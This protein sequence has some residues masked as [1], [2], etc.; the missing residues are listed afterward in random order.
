MS[1][2]V[3]ARGFRAVAASGTT[4][5]TAQ[6]AINKV[7]TLASMWLVAL[8]LTP[9]EFGMATL[10]LSVGMF[11][12]VLPPMTMGDVLVTHA[13]RFERLARI[14]SRIANTIGL[15]TLIGIALL[16][17][18][19]GRAYR[20]YPT[21]IL[22]GLIW[23]VSLR[24]MA[25][26]L[27]SVPLAR[28]RIGYRYKAIALI[29]GFTQIGATLLTV[30]LAW[31]GTGALAMVLP[32]VAVAFVRAVLYI[33][34]PRER[35][36]VS[37]RVYEGPE[38]T[39]EERRTLVGEFMIAS[40]AQYVHN[41]LVMLP[42]LVL[43]FFSTENETGLYAFA[44]T[45]SAQ[46]NT[47]VAAQ[48]GTVLQPIFVGLGTGSLRQVE[49][50]LRVV[51]VI[52]AAAVPVCL[53]QAALAEP[54][55]DLVFQDKWHGAIGVFAVL[56]IL[57]SSYFATAPTMAMLRAQGRFGAYFGW[58]VT[59][60]TVAVIAFTF[61]ARDHGA[62]GVAAC[63][64]VIWMAALPVA[65][66]LCTRPP[67]GTVSGA[68]RV[69]LMPWITGVPIALGAWFAWTLL[70][71]LGTPGMVIALLVV[72]PV[73]LWLSMI[74]TRAFQ[75][76]E[77]DELAR[78][79]GGVVR[80]VLR[81]SAA[82]ATRKPQ[83][84]VMYHFYPHYRRAIVETLARSEVADFTF[85]GD[86]HEYLRS[87]EPAK[88]SS[89]V[90]FVLAPTHHM[91]GPFMWQWGAIAIAWDR[92]FDTV[93]FHPVPHWPCTWIGAVLARIFG[94][95][96]LYWGH[97]ILETPRGV[98]GMLR[99]AFNALPHIQM[100]YSRRP[101]A[102][103]IADGWPPETLHVI[104][105]SED[106][107][108]QIAAR[109]RVTLERRRAVRRE[110]FGDDAT[111]VL[112][113]TARLIAIR[114]FDLLVEA[115]AILNRDGHPVNL[116]LV[117]DGPERTRLEAL[118]RERGVRAHFEGACYDEH[119]L[120]ELTMACNASVLPGR[121]G[122]TA[123]HSMVYGV[124]VVTHSDADDQHPEFEAIIPGRT[125]ALFTKDDAQSLADAL[126]PLIST[127]FPSAE[128]SAACHGIVE[129]FWNPTYQRRAIERA[130][131]G[132]PADDLFDL[133]EPRPA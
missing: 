74:A 49:G 12:V 122:L 58:Q 7:L 38:C 126:K 17:P 115:A 21:G 95:R 19:I 18:V 100:F 37:R 66:W 91:G 44:Y 68:I 110:L 116:L 28:L 70:K 119:R 1:E 36:E 113:C 114:K 106:L 71:P 128:I 101:K 3:A 48:L 109:D 131:C 124:P 35:D 82:T 43:G 39:R 55:L 107:S 4:W 45:L 72:G 79:F 41:I 52:G 62:F 75:R 129:R 120:A 8:F 99:R 76:T 104:Y 118:A 90:R 67:G 98:K 73:A 69:F 16:A 77:Y 87:I 2:Q 96:V 112:G 133:R 60:F 13:A 123:T 54:L 14:G 93:V 47:L 15:A 23:V 80:R 32:Q 53:L 33:R 63:S 10:V 102:F 105:N 111:P 97:G 51:R 81:R 22:V 42:V 103:A 84:A 86:D 20:E 83:V 88:L 94:K 26:G 24:S 57:E 127:P 50:F 31:A 56:S 121:V 5:T 108:E 130:V 29:D 117:G 30:A 85:F 132:L 59:Q 6:V 27:A 11:L 9:E 61:V 46:A 78:L 25:L 64:A 34:G 89:Q 92:R 65:V 125:G 40:S